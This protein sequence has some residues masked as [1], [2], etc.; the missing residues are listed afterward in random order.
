MEKT[1]TS[2]LIAEMRRV[3]D[4]VMPSRILEEFRGSSVA[5]AELTVVRELLDGGIAALADQ[6]AEKCLEVFGELKAIRG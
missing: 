6:D 5:T 2:R 4:E 1:L 3:R